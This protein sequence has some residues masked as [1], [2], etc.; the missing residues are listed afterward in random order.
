DPRG[1]PL[2]AR[3]PAIAAP[4]TRR[5]RGDVGARAPSA[6]AARQRGGRAGRQ[7]PRAG[8]ARGRRRRCRRPPPGGRQLMATPSDLT[9]LGIAKEVTPGTYIAPTA[10]LGAS[11][12][13]ILNP[14]DYMKVPGF[15]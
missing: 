6:P 13:K 11:K 12:I 9:F 10:Y 1:V 2:P 15:R 8:R 14:I 5:H 4:A 3:R 7:N